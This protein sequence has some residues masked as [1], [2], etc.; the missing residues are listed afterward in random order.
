MTKPDHPQLLL[1]RDSRKSL[2]EQWAQGIANL[3]VQR[4][5]TTRLWALRV[6]QVT[7]TSTS[8]L[9]RPRLWSSR[10]RR[11]VLVPE[12]KCTRPGSSTRALKTAN[13][14]IN[15]CPVEWVHSTLAQR[16]FQRQQSEYLANVTIVK[17]YEYCDKWRGLATLTGNKNGNP[18]HNRSG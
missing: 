10:G 1:Q 9:L 5:G 14:I 16:I 13:L 11:G 3:G 15:W 6:P 12:F 2:W 7:L 18:D 17:W 4:I 8:H